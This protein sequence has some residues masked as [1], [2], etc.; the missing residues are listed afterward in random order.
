[1]EGSR[2]STASPSAAYFR[3]PAAEAFYPYIESLTDKVLSEGEKRFSQLISQFEGSRFS[4]S[5]PKNLTRNEALLDIL[6]LGSLWNL[7]K[8]QWGNSSLR[9]TERIYKKMHQLQAA[10]SD[11]SAKVEKL[12]QKLA[13]RVLNNPGYTRG[14]FT[15]D[16]FKLLCIWL[17]ATNEF[18]EEAFRMYPWISF[19]DT[20]PAVMAHQYLGGII[21]FA[22]W[23]DMESHR[24]YR[25]FSATYNGLS[26]PFNRGEK[27]R[28]PKYRN[29]REEVEYHL[30][31]VGATLLN[32][33]MRPAFQG[34]KHQI[35]FLPGRLAKSENCQ[36]VEILKG[37]VCSHC[38]ADCEIAKISLELKE[39]GIYT[40][41]INEPSGIS[42]YL[43][44]W[45]NQTEVGI[46]GIHHALDLL[47]ISLEMRRR[48]IPSQCLPLEY[49][50][51]RKFLVS[52][53]KRAVS[54]PT[55]QIRKNIQYSE[56]N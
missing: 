32:R 27:G 24:E 46:M 38:T 13:R 47:S 40:F 23:F 43:D 54:N 21:D 19:F 25:K 1:M 51:A 6:I 45:T 34:S 16:Q 4:H 39:L 14:D 30:N 17:S 44:K 12:R 49:N 8:G 22:N 29:G 20:I 15:P 9:N 56:V 10:P 18:S 7:Y 42:E 5:F 31:L 52:P 41:L 36:S 28:N 11:H 48:N 26:K 3:I 33:K 2:I 50:N 37:S 53:E 55:F 35:V